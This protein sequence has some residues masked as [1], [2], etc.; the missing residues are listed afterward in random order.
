M[1][2]IILMAIVSTSIMVNSIVPTMAEDKTTI[3][4]V[5]NNINYGQIVNNTNIDS[6]NTNTTNV[7]NNN[8]NSKVETLSDLQNEL[9]TKYNTLNTPIGMLKFKFTINTDTYGVADYDYWVQTEFGEISNS[10]YQITIF[11]PYLLE[12]S[13]KISSEDK[14][15]T[16]ELLRNYQKLIGDAFIYGCGKS[17]TKVMGGFFDSFYEYP[18]LKVGYSKTQFLTWKNYNE[19]G[20]ITDF[21]WDT[22]IDDYDFTK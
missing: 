16:K 17:N 13:T 22:T 12:Y 3:N 18:N 5:T 15:K 14:I 21:H 8:G 7:N 1:K 20:N 9:N 19:N 2:K 4:N 6:N 10:P 11:H